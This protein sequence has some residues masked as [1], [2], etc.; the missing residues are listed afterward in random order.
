MKYDN[1]LLFKQSLFCVHGICQNTTPSVMSFTLFLKGALLFLTEYFYRVI[2]IQYLFCFQHFPFVMNCFGEDFWVNIQTPGVYFPEFM[3][4]VIKEN[5]REK[6]GM[7][8]KR[9]RMQFPFKQGQLSHWET[10]EKTNFSILSCMG[11]GR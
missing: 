7:V 4:P 8:E 3:P 6:V 1:L 10:P 5:Q 2:K 9:T 11:G